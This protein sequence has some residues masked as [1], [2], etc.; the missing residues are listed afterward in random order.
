MREM[1]RA[2]I[3]SLAFIGMLLAA[4]FLAVW[5]GLA[6][7]G[8]HFLSAL[9][10]GVTAYCLG[11]LPGLGVAV[12]GALL[13]VGSTIM[14]TPMTPRAVETTILLLLYVFTAVTLGVIRGLRNKVYELNR[15]LLAFRRATFALHAEVDLGG[16]FERYVRMVVEELGFSDA[17]ILLLDDEGWLEMKA[18][19]NFSPEWG[20]G[21]RLAPGVGL[22]WEAVEEGRTVVREN[23]YR[24]P[25]YVRGVEG[26]RTQVS[27]PISMGGHVVGVLIVEAMEE[28]PPSQDSVGILTAL[29]EQ[30]GVAMEKAALLEETRKLAM[31]DGLTGAFN[32][33]HFKERLKEEV[34]R[35]RRFSREVALIMLDVDD[36]KSTNDRYG[37]IVGDGVLKA[38]ARILRA[39]CR[40]IDVVARYGGDE[41]AVVA[42]DTGREDAEAMANRIKE[43][44]ARGDAESPQGPPCLTAGIG[45]AVYPWDA[46][47]WESLLSRADAR[48]YTAKKG[49][50]RAR[51]ASR[52]SCK[53]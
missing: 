6:Q 24:D 32:H 15:R 38:F 20:P 40:E 45:V 31:L 4:V 27:I 46:D 35:A 51:P 18:A 25:R 34:E 36:L 11:M 17:A 52:V 47:D 13:V 8:L 12:A 41:F 42:P 23:C 14:R 10:V 3:V 21:F 33:R 48:L 28:G 53:D 5:H 49:R 26:A 16:L 2:H 50:R 30:A 22:C 9:G 44:L 43:A 29:S 1:K 39:T 37:H 7:P 19:A